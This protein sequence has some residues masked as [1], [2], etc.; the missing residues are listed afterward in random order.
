MR[1]GIEIDRLFKM[2][3]NRY[4]LLLVFY[5]FMTGIHT[6]S[7]ETY[8]CKNYAYNTN[9]LSYMQRIMHEVILVILALLHIVE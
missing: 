4:N 3:S 9:S 6:K 8:W 5:E 2:T 1:K 7:Q